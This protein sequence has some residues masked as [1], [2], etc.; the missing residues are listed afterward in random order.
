MPKF[1]V[2]IRQRIKEMATVV[3]EANSQRE[4][5]DCLSKIYRELA[6]EATWE[7]DPRDEPEEGRHIILGEASPETV[8]QMRLK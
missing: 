1:K 4:L 2:Q 3:V 7:V 6:G 5:A 8:P